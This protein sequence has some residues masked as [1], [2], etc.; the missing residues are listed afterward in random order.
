MWLEWSGVE[1]TGLE[2]G[3]RTSH[4]LVPAGAR[5]R[6][7]AKRGD[8]WDRCVP[9]LASSWLGLDGVV[10]HETGARGG[11][12][13]RWVAL[14]RVVLLGGR[15]YAD[16]RCMRGSRLAL[17]SILVGIVYPS[18]CLRRD[19]RTREIDGDVQVV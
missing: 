7:Q 5:R 18:I 14:G 2:S 13:A 10:K 4:V 12:S 17:A 16:L 1:W 6:G 8:G 9:T 3:A 19:C 11:G 15:L